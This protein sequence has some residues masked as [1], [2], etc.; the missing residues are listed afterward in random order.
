M[1]RTNEDH[2]LESMILILCLVRHFETYEQLPLSIKRLYKRALGLHH[3]SLQ[4][5]ISYEFIGVGPT[6]EIGSAIFDKNLKL[7]IV[8]KPENYLFIS[9]DKEKVL[10]MKRLLRQS[11]DFIWDQVIGRLL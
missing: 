6:K 9:R 1:K 7:S 5:L 8:V 10:E 3:E 11:I 2:S 4:N